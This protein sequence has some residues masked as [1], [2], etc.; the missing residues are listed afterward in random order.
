M[1]RSPVRALA[2]TVLVAT[3]LSACGLKPEVKAQL[4]Q[5]NLGGGVGTTDGGTIGSDTG[6][7]SGTGTTGSS[8]SGTGTTGSSGTTG[9]SGGSGTSGSGSTSGSTTGTSGSG[10][11]GIAPEPG[12][13]TTT[14][15]DFKN[16]VVR[17]ALHGPL[18]GAGVPQDSF[19]SGTPKYWAKHKLA[20]GFRV[21]AVAIDDKYNAAD[22]ARACN[23]AA[24][25][26]FL[27][28]GGAGTDQIS[29]CAQSPKLRRLKVPY[30]SS[31]VTEVGLTNID[32]YHATSLS[33]RQQA[34]LVIKLAKDRGEFTGKKWAVVITSTPNFKDA[35]EAF[36]AELQ[37]NGA[38]GK[39]GAFN[40]SSDVYLT[41][42]AP[43]NCSSL[44]PQIRAGGYQSIYFL[45]QPSFFAQC[46]GSIGTTPV[47]PYYTGPGPSFGLTSV[48]A[49]ACTGSANQYKG[50]FLHPAPSVKEY[51]PRTAPGETFK[52]D[53]EL[54]IWGAMEQLKHAF[55]RVQGPL[56]RESFNASLAGAQLPG[57]VLPAV[58]YRQGR[59]GGTAAYANAADCAN[60]VSKTIGV[61][62][63]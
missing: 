31:G 7:T 28:V 57:N 60:R 37:K 4:S 63:K 48:I 20:N 54:S 15:I 40:P 39:S 56:S 46:V 11:T 32:T 26:Y 24:D 38:K 12:Q 30:M 35:R 19:K 2:L 16:K 34:P 36:V 53:I 42:K 47:N 8:S 45:G 29:A 17:I 1:S 5:G 49:L 51:A 41:D 33:Y 9:T 27:I 3:A 13:G 44:A 21:E 52:D 25:N 50:V 14:G 23:A 55:D 43:S 22:A 18:T 61:Y 58:D 59:F 6:S 10:T 62:A